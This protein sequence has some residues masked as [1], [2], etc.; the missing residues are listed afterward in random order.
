MT[1]ITDTLGYMLQGVSQQQPKVRHLGQVSEQINLFSD[2]NIGLTTRPPT[3]SIGEVLPSFAGNK[4]NTIQIGQ[5]RYRVI[6]GDGSI[7]VIGYDGLDRTVTATPSA[8]E[9]V[10]PDA[11]I[12]TYNN[13][14]YIANRNKIVASDPT[15]RP[16]QDVLTNWAYVMALGAAF[17]RNYRWTLRISGVNYDVSYQ[18]PSGTGGG[19]A[20]LTTPQY[21]AGQLRQLMQV[22]L[23]DANVQGITMEQYNGIISVRSSNGSIQASSTLDGDAG[24]IL[25]TG[26]NEVDSLDLLPK[27]APQ[28]AYVLVRG[29]TSSDDDYWMRFQ[30]DNQAI[31]LGTGFSLKGRW[32]EV[33]DINSKLRFAPDTMPHKLVRLPNGNFEFGPTV[34]EP[35]R[36]GN[37]ESAKTPSFFGAAI[38]DI[39]EFQGRLAFATSAS[40]VV[41]SRTDHPQDFFPK[42]AT[43]L[44]A[45]DPIDI[46]SSR[47]GTAALEW[48][49]PFDRDMFVMAENAQYVIAGGPVGSGITPTS[50]NMVLATN[51]TM[52]LNARPESTGRTVLLPYYGSAYSGVN[53]YFTADDVA[54]NSVDNLTKTASRYIEGEIR[55]I[56]VATNEGVAFFLTDKS[57]TDGTVWVY[58]FM[59]EGMDKAQ[60]S[61]SKWQFSGRVMHMSYHKG[62]MYFWHQIGRTD[63]GSWIARRD[64][65]SYARLDLLPSFNAPFPFSMDASIGEPPRVVDQENET[66]TYTITH[67]DPTFVVLR[68]GNAAPI[69]DEVFPDSITTIGTGTS[70]KTVC[71]FDTTRRTWL[72]NAA[73]SVGQRIS[74]TFIP[75]EPV[76][77]N[78]RDG[79]PRSDVALNVQQYFVDYVN[80]GP[81]KVSMRSPYRDEAVM[82]D[83]EWFPYEDINAGNDWRVTLRSGT[84]QVPWGEQ[85]S[86]ST[87]IITTDSP[88]PI[89]IHE[90]RFQAEAL[91]QGG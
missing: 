27:F 9:Y 71:V 40:T 41:M 7:R 68:G 82:V 59:W 1:L 11:A 76:P 81:F 22:K 4:S 75:S 3:I 17:S 64:V 72:R 49:V 13:E 74:T 46:R 24:E 15:H 30:M 57:Y 79:S 14:A 37:T 80:S 66:V 34:W 77:R 69:G 84:L 21:V 54:T 60:S 38:R 43:T 12:Y 53:E 86:T 42:T 87:V 2:V 26:V 50:A 16:D 62:N 18:T 47:E 58:K 78:P 55:E 5:D 90:V 44:V 85:A 10:S 89:T 32:L 70:E 33:A 48:M 61:W 51:Y 88:R 91:K 73:L 63:G 52:S 67:T 35:R 56:V 45:T 29:D 25:H 8:L 83:T 6:L 23:D 36:V 19:D 20:G 31:P 39:R 65:L 28:G